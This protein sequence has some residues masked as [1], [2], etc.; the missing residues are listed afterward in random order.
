[1]N[2]LSEQ[3]P[4]AYSQSNSTAE[5]KWLEYPLYVGGEGFGCWNT[6]KI[7]AIRLLLS[8]SAETKGGTAKR[9]PKGGPA[10][11]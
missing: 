1:M 5:R 9:I 11:C 7:A 4:A 8:C 10:S 2:C 6:G 3:E